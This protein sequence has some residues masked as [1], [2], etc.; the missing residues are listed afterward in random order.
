MANKLSNLEIFGEFN[1]I[2][3]K[4]QI[5]RDGLFISLDFTFKHFSHKNNRQIYVNH[6]LGKFL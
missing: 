5:K 4:S 2:V 6:I 3:F 1:S